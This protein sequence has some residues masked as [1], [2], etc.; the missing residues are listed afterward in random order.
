MYQLTYS[1]IARLGLKIDDLENILKEAN[2]TNSTMKISGCLIYH[3]EIFVQILEGAEKDVRE[4]FEKIKN[5][6]R[7]HSI[8]LLWD[9][10]TDSRTFEEWNMAFY[11]ADEKS[12]K[13]FIENLL[14]LSDYSDKSTSSLLSFW[15]EIGKILRVNMSNH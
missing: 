15:A 6:D 10:Q 14:L 12:G 3:N 7:H 2:A 5:D 1:S 11:R 13:L 8:K 4:V 9:N